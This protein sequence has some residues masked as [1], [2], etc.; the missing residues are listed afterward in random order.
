MQPLR[1]H[2]SQRLGDL[3]RSVAGVLRLYN[4]RKPELSDALLR[5]LDDAA[6]VYKERGRGEGHIQ[7]LKA[8]LMTA[9][10]GIHPITLEKPSVRRHEMQTAIAFRVL[11]SI[12]SRVRSD[13]EPLDETLRRAEDLLGQIVAAAMQKGALLGAPEA[14]WNTIAADAELAVAQKRVLLMV[15]RT[16]ALL[17]LEGLVAGVV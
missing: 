16:D 14:L 4:E 8:E 5:L 17:L 6:V 15:S 2:E 1:I 3:E 9:L 13:L 11:Q 7:S 12:E 10:R